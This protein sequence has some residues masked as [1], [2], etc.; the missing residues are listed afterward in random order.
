MSIELVMLANHFILPYPFLLLPSVSHSIKVFS[1]ELAVH[2]RWSKYWSFSISPS[3]EYS[4]LIY[5][6]LTGL[7]S[8]KSKGLSTVFSSTT[9]QKHQLILQHSAF[10][11]IQ[12]SHDYWKNHSFDHTN[13][14]WQSDLSP[15]EYAIKVCHSFPS[16][17]RGSINF[18]A[19]VI[20]CSDFGAQENKVCHCF[21]FSP[22][23]L[24]W[25]NRTA[26]HGTTD[27]FQ[28]RKGVHQ[29]CILSPCLFNSHAEY[30][31][32]SSGLE[33]AQAGIKIAGRNINNLWYADDTT[34]MAESEEE[35]KSLL[36]N[37]KEEWKSWL[38]AQHSENKDHGI[39]SHHFMGNRWGN[40]GNSVRLY[41]GG[42]QNHCRWWLKPWN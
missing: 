13:L 5:L 28:I 38:K 16:K 15:S 17:E 25:S 18:M 33:E 31:M 30:V 23:Y 6:G 8:L 9:V 29:G 12:F 3:S 42:L 27:W 35:L 7:I 22:L 20:I 10:F 37:V 36:M 19:A 26:G 21:Q 2:I 14:C 34:L 39:W 4:G 40:S 24:L 11:M 32:R 41:F 1:N